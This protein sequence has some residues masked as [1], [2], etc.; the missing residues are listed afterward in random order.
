M[1]SKNRPADFGSRFWFFSASSG[2]YFNSYLRDFLFIVPRAGFES[3]VCFESD[4]PLTRRKGRSER[5]RNHISETTA[6]SK[7]E[8]WIELLSSSS[9]SFEG[10]EEVFK[11][12][13]AQ[14]ACLSSLWS[15]FHAVSFSRRGKF[16]DVGD[17]KKVEQRKK[18]KFIHSTINFSCLDG[19]DL[20][21]FIFHYGRH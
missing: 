13:S 3:D 18:R 14:L 17:I 19:C 2:C 21:R 20:T 5:E 4:S 11:L 12:S 10:E 1:E 9:G 6:K 15:L 8:N 7:K 16:V